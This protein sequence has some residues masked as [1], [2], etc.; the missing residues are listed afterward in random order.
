M[1]F[2]PGAEKAHQTDPKTYACGFH[3]R[4]PIRCFLEQQ[5]IH[6]QGHKETEENQQEPEYL[7][8]REDIKQS[9]HQDCPDRSS[10]IF[11]NTQPG[12]APVDLLQMAQG[13]H[14]SGKIST[15]LN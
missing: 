6:W 2:A 14:I 7:Y 15:E 11:A 13:H 8:N 1:A 9:H 10:I 12:T 3:E 4:L 5:K